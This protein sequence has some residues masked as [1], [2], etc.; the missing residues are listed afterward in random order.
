MKRIISFLIIF[1]MLCS[2][3]L[4]AIPVFADAKSD[5]EELV[6]EA[7]LLKER[8]Y[9][10]ES[11][12]YFQIVL[13]GAKD[14]LAEQSPN[15]IRI[16]SLIDSLQK[17]IDD[18]KIVTIEDLKAKVDYA[19][20]IDA[21]GYT[22][23]TWTALSRAISDAED[24]YDDN[25]DQSTVDEDELCEYYYALN[26]A[27]QNLKSYTYELQVLVA[28]AKVIYDAHT[29]AVSLD[30]VGDYTAASFEPFA[31][32][33]N[34]ARLYVKS[35]DLE[36]VNRFVKELDDAMNALE[37]LQVPESLK[38]DLAELVDLAQ[39]LVPSHWSE[40]AWTMVEMKLE[41]AKKVEN[42][43]KISTYA[44][45]ESELRLALMNLTNEDKPDKDTLPQ[46]PEV[47][48]YYL[49]D[50]IKWCKDHIVERGHTEE[51]WNE[52]LQ[53]LENAKAVLNN[54][55]NDNTVK[56]A[57]ENLN[58]ARKALEVIEGEDV[59]SAIKSLIEEIEALDPDG[60]TPDSWA[61]I[62]NALEGA[63]R[64]TESSF[65]REVE[66]ALTALEKA[67]EN[68]VVVSD[69]TSE[70]EETQQ[71]Q[72]PEEQTDIVDASPLEEP[73]NS[74]CSSAIGSAFS[75]VA[76][77]LGLGTAM[78]FKKKEN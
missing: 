29:Y 60:F 44:R 1:S 66:A 20:A 31:A 35:D 69:K 41:Q 17:A 18:L 24:F 56:A 25:F 32:A 49:E 37:V 2:T 28:R 64:V 16:V 51:S 36:L 4:T 6:D 54:P 42:N 8:K 21:D 68:L 74:G 15:E 43:P 7:E 26:Q 63:K 13:S 71:P 14:I 47:Y 11:W 9:T 30:Y 78:I 59:W 19:K 40:T 10:A 61:N 53:A 57:W 67:K 5:L 73:E 55:Q 77:V 62:A 12:S 48:T 22:N 70:N 39:A 50:L 34:E 27:I 45:A 46:R 38:K 72:A 23:E 3:M 76:A 52:Y 65:P 58:D 75:V 33:Y